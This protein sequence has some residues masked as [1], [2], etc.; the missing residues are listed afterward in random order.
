M[1]QF[2][3]TDVYTGMR[4]IERWYNV[5][6]VYEGSVPQKEFVGKIPKQSTISE[7]LQILEL[8]DIH[9]LMEGR[10]ITVLR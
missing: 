6:V 8:S 4:Q 5:E 3:R 1:L 10:K 9:C 7:V 2:N